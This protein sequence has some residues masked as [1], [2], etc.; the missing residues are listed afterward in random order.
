MH[1]QHK[2]YNMSSLSLHGS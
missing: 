2:H 1:P